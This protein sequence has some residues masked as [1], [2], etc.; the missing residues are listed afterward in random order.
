MNRVIIV[1]ALMLVVP[2]SVPTS[3]VVVQ[4]ASALASV[5]QITS[6]RSD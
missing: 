6:V 5:V 4:N 2:L 3:V 1:L